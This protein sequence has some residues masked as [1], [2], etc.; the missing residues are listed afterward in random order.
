MR[1]AGMWSSG[2]AAV[3]A[4]F[5]TTAVASGC[6]VVPAWAVF[7]GGATRAATR[8]AF[9]STGTS[10]MMT[11]MPLRM[12]GVGAALAMTG[13]DPVAT[14]AFVLTATGAA[15]CLAAGVMTTAT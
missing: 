1:R 15:P 11:L 9:G 13:F 2:F 12:I 5:A 3:L 14:G 10:C 7:T 4:G 8:P 6:G